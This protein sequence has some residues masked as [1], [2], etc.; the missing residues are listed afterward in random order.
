MGVRGHIDKDTQISTPVSVSDGGTGDTSLTGV[1]TGNGTSPITGNSVTEGGVL[2]AGS[3]NSVTDTG[4]LAK[5]VLLV[6]DGAGA[7]TELAVGSNDDVLTADSSESSG[8]KWAAPAGGGGSLVFLGTASASSSAAVEFTSLITSTYKNYMLQC[9]EV[10]PAQDDDELRVRFSNDNGVSYETTGYDSVCVE[11]DSSP[12]T[13]TSTAALVI[14]KDQGSAAGESG[15]SIYWICNP[16]PSSSTT[17]CYG[18]GSIIDNGGI[19]RSNINT[20][21]YQVAE[22]VNALQITFT[23]DDIASGRF[24]LF[25]IVNS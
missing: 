24:D 6:G 21:E 15:S 4:V 25:G 13:E 11:V 10:V 9:T 19:I 3:S 16:E 17:M 20:G 22:T 1:L 12:T 23:S 8:V 7:P 5:G 2:L 18:Q 14:S